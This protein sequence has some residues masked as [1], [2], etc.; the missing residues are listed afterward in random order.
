MTRIC[1]VLDDAITW[2][3]RVGLAHLV[4]RLPL[5]EYTHRVLAPAPVLPRLTGGLERSVEQTP[6]PFTRSLPSGLFFAHHARRRSFDVIHAWGIGAAAAARLAGG[7]LPLIVQL[8]DPAL[9]AK[10]L[11]LLRS[12]GRQRGFAIACSS[13]II[14]R[15]LIEGGVP[16]DVLVVVRPGVDFAAIHRWR[17]GP[18]RRALGIR[19]DERIVL[20]TEPVTVSGGHFEAFRA[21]SLRACLVDDH[22]IIVPG[23]SREQARIARYNASL[24]VSVGLVS[25]GPGVPFE[26]LVAVSDVMLMAPRDD[27]PTTAIAWAMGA[28]VGVVGTAVYAIAEMIAHKLNGLLVKPERGKSIVKPL[29]AALADRASLAKTIETAHGQAYEIFSMRRYTELTVR[30]YRNVI[31]GLPADHGIVDTATVA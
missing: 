26:Q 24:P 30:L 17:R 6:I 12:I 28:R 14:R 16:A 31:E 18:L 25:S 11:K 8:D 2:E 1:H 29:A 5:D 20:L 21:A 7:H 9:S 10:D 22:R 13:Q 3:H 4:D 27:C 23:A 19:P 15:R